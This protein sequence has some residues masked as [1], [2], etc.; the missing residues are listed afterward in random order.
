MRSSSERETSP[1]S[2]AP[3]RRPF[4]QRLDGWAGSRWGG[5][6]TALAAILAGG[7]ALRAVG[8]QYGLPFGA[9]LNPDEQLIVPRAWKLVHGGGGDPH[10]FDYPT[11][12]MYVNAPF[13]WWPSQP[14][15]L[16]ARVVAALLGVGAVAATWWLGRAAYRSAGAGA[17]AAAIGAGGRRARPRPPP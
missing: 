1:D 13:Q 8:I 4:R 6:G 11:L 12:L 7:A 2:S 10:W 17:G 14:S 5:A 3:P 9:I 16:T 15:F